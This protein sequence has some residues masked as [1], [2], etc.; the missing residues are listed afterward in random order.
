MKRIVLT[1]QPK[2][3]T[4]ETLKKAKRLVDP[5]TGIIKTVYHVRVHPDDPQLFYYSAHLANTSRYARL[6]CHRWASGVALASDR[7]LASVIG[8]AVERYSPVMHY[9]CEKE[10]LIE[11]SFSEIRDEALDPRVFPLCSEREYAQNEGNDWTLVRFSEEAT[12]K[13]VWGYMLG[14]ETAILVPACFVYLPYLFERREEFIWLPASTGLACGNSLEEAMFRG[15]LEVVERD[16]FAIMWLNRLPMPSVDIFSSQNADLQEIRTR[17]ETTNSAVYVNNITTDI[18]IPAFCAWIIDRSGR[19]PAIG[20][21]A[22]AHLNPEVAIRKALEEAIHDRMWLRGL[23][24]YASGDATYATDSRDVTRFEDHALLYS[25]FDMLPHLDF[26]LN[27]P[28]KVKVSDIEDLSSGDLIFDI[29]RLL[30]RVVERV[31]DVVVVDITSPDIAEVGFNVARVLIP[32]MQ[33]LSEDHRFRFLG[34]TR[35][36]EMPRLLGYSQNDSMEEKLNP[37]P[38]PFP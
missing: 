12:M 5:M 28:S 2:F 7:A 33:P 1:S 14:K 17:I 10:N 37:Y 36:Y 29:E 26:I 6:E 13:W 23:T 8:E 11:D 35:V 25:R 18:G 9:E 27:P 21:G 31:G 3:D 22:S 32:G 24:K 34:G 20:V 15:I 30:S 4:T 19:G 38:H 16:A